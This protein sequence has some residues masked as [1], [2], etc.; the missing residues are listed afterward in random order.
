MQI[1][2]NMQKGTRLPLLMENGAEVQTLEELKE[3]FSAEAVWEYWNSG[4]L[5]KWLEARYYQ[6]IVEELEKIE[7][8]SNVNG[9]LYEIFGV[10][11]PEM[12]VKKKEQHQMHQEKLNKLRES[13][14][15]KD[16]DRYKQFVDKMAFTQEDLY[17]FL[18]AG[19]GEV[20]LCGE[21]FEIPLSVEN[22]SYIG[23]NNPLV[24]IRVKKRVDLGREKKIQI[25]DVRFG[26][27]VLKDAAI[28]KLFGCYIDCEYNFI[29]RRDSIKD[30]LEEE[31]LEKSNLCSDMRELTGEVEDELAIYEIWNSKEKEK[32]AE[33]MKEY[34]Y[35]I[36]KLYQACFG[37]EHDPIASVGREIGKI[38]GLKH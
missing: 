35:V 2:T 17:E 31:G 36:E 4:E 8:A 29:E 6:D 11:N 22:I 34:G 38:F 32:C 16:F 21:K 37:E 1:R 13:V 24:K 20:Y 12:S 25:K 3:N 23:V 18:D 30:I 26:E 19:L 10:E 5:R 7:G 14:D 9:S 33:L 27:T 15:E 28:G